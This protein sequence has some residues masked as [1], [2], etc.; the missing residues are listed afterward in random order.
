MQSIIP[1]QMLHKSVRV[2]LTRVIA[3][4]IAFKIHYI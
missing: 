2:A 3:S 4:F 1:K